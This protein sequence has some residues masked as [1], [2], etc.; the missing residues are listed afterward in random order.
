[1]IDNGKQV[2]HKSEKGGSGSDERA[3]SRAA[4]LGTPRFIL[5][6]VSMNGFSES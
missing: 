1:M 6:L 5:K 4:E 2:I 3:R